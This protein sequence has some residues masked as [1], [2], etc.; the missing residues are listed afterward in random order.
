M[1]KMSLMSLLNYTDYLDKCLYF[2]NP[3]PRLKPWAMEKR[4]KKLKNKNHSPR[5]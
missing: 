5:F 3:P 2:F 4:K 1:G